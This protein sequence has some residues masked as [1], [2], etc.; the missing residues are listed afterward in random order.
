M[1][2]LKI[3]IALLLFNSISF[4][5]VAQNDTLPRPTA[6][7]KVEAIA[8]RLQRDLSLSKKQTDKVLPI[9]NQRS[10]LISKR[11][12]LDSN[13]DLQQINS[14]TLQ[15]LK[16]VLTKEQF[17]KLQQLQEDTQTQRS[18]LRNKKERISQTQEDRELDF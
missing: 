1:N 18:A 5:T 12:E 15:Q 9:L 13:A 8:L 2:N 10:I 16:P 14:E 3:F 17:F 6:K 7:Q 4:F 11:F